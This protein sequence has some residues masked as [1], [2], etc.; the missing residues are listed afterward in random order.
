MTIQARN[1]ITIE[2]VARVAGVSRAAVSKVIRDAYGVSDAM[3]ERVQAAIDE[4]GYRPRASARAM[5]GSS[6]TLGVEIPSIHNHFFPKIITG[7]MTALADTRYQL[8]IAPAGPDH[9]EGPQAIQVLV[10]R[11]VDG[12]VAISSRVPQEWLENLGRSVPL[13]MIGRHHASEHYDTLVG[14]DVMGAELALRHLHELGHRRI[15]HLT[16]AEYGPDTMPGTPHG[17]R[18]IGYQRA[19]A[20]LGLTPEI[21]W[22]EPHQ[23]AARDGALHLLSRAGGPVGVFAAHDELALGVLE[24]VAELG[25]TPGQASVVGYDDTDVAAHPMMSLTSVNQSGTQMGAIAMRLLLERI[26]GR[27]SAVHEVLTPKVMARRS[28]APPPDAPASGRAG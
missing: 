1:S 4:L 12:I 2:D 13:V 19:M 27:T 7:A 18:V 24:A 22:V 6:Y 20:D 17:Q 8:I 23:E 28:S 14:D 10:D 9:D 25:L 3:R 16:L 26:G 15:V 11:Q 21:V 5:R